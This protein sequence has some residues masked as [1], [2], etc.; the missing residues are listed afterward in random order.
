MFSFENSWLVCM[1]GW[2]GFFLGLFFNEQDPSIGKMWL[3][4]DE[5]EQEGTNMLD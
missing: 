2:F 3:S 1:V 4:G 5:N